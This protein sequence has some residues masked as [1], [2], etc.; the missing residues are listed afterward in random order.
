[1]SYID[2]INTLNIDHQPLGKEEMKMRRRIPF[3]LFLLIVLSFAITAEASELTFTAIPDQDTAR[4]QQ[5]FDKIAAYLSKRLDTPVRYIPVKSYA[6]TPGRLRSSLFSSGSASIMANAKA[7]THFTSFLTRCRLESRAFNI[8]VAKY[9]KV[10][11]RVKAR[12][13]FQDMTITLENIV[14]V[15]FP[16]FLGV[17]KDNK[18]VVVF[19][20]ILQ[21]G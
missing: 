16:K 15:F 10:I 5:R 18:G 20:I 4:L 3:A 9:P 19:Q 11:F 21:R 14:D 17:S 1:M 12:F 8:V 2:L 13:F 6:A 7:G